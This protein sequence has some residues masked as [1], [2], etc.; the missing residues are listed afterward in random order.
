MTRKAWNNNLDPCPG[1]HP[2]PCGQADLCCQGRH[3]D[4]PA[5]HPPCPLPSQC[6]RRSLKPWPTCC[7]GTARWTTCRTWTRS[8]SGAPP[9]GCPAV[10]SP[11][12]PRTGASSPFWSHR[13][14]G[15]QSQN[16]RP[17]RARGRRSMAH[18]SGRIPFADQH[19]IMLAAKPSAKRPTFST[20]QRILKS[21]GSIYIHCDWHI[22]FHYLKVLAD[23]IFG[24]NNFLNE[25]IWKRQSSHNDAKQGSKHFGRIHDTI[26]V[27]AG[28]QKYTWNQEFV[29][30][31]KIYVERTYKY[32]ESATERKYAFRRHNWSRRGFKRKSSLRVFRD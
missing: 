11:R 32:V 31:D 29:P 3:Q 24:R 13:R 15:P 21:A 7:A 16:R 2:R 1:C 28:S 5:N 18:R 19:Q 23:G 8:G 20:F 27:Y 22:Y 14:R 25:I 10:I 17:V 6:K 26:L 9:L 30:Y 12:A 4:T